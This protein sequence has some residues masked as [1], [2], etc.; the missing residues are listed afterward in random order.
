MFHIDEDAINLFNSGKDTQGKRI[1]FVQAHPT[2]VLDTRHFDADFTDHLL[3]SFDD[4]DG[5]TDGLLIHGDNWQALN[6]LREKYAEEVKCIYIDPLYN[7][8]EDGF[9]YKDYY[10]HCSTWLSMM[11]NLMPSWLQLLANSGSF[12]SHIDEHEFNRLEQLISMRFGPEQNVGPI[13]WDKR[14]PK[15]MQPRLQVSTSIYAGQSKTI[16]R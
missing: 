11:D 5:M 12:V 13:V 6:L 8:G 1:A 9:L 14:I 7:T 3:A 2:L 10:Q 16:T 4:L 15:V